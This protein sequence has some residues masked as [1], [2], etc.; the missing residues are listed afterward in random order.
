MTRQRWMTLTLALV[1]AVLLPA[2]V[3]ARDASN[4]EAAK[5]AGNALV[6][7]PVIS[8]QTVGLGSDVSSLTI[9]NDRHAIYFDGGQ[10]CEALLTKEELQA[11]YKGILTSDAG[12]L[13]DQFVPDSA[14]HVPF[15][16]VT[17]FQQVEHSGHALANTFT[18]YESVRRYK[19]LQD[20]IYSVVESSGLDACD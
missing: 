20:A 17:V 11:I 3:L 7:E 8:I 2:A 4:P 5:V 18:Y 9:W 10:V 16:T 6:Y 13:Y 1:V 14:A 15:T 12:E 19:R